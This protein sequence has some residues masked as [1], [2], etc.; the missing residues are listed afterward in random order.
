MFSLIIDALF[1]CS[2]DKVEALSVARCLIKAGAKVNACDKKQRTP[3]HLAVNGNAG[4]SDSSTAM[5]LL[6]LEHGANPMAADC[7]NRIPLHYVFTKIGQ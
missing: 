2:T 4:G 1:M 7:R 3:L 6:L 5:E